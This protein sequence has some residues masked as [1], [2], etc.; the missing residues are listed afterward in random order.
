MI[1]EKVISGQKSS[2]VRFIKTLDLY[3][4]PLDF[5]GWY[6]AAATQIYYPT[7]T[8][9]FKGAWSVFARGSFWLCS[10]DIPCRD[11][12][13][14][15]SVKLVKPCGCTK[16]FCSFQPTVPLMFNYGYHSCSHFHRFLMNGAYFCWKIFNGVCEKCNLFITKIAKR[17]G[18]KSEKSDKASLIR[19]K[20][21][22]WSII[23]GTHLLKICMFVRDLVTQIFMAHSSVTFVTFWCNIFVTFVTFLI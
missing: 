18:K 9:I 4:L 20:Y 12:N 7:Q 14:T 11:L 5:V 19:L 22:H 2:V 15:T 23:K 21:S 16:Q 6:K 13:F 17:L 8:C 1:Y 3:R 10:L